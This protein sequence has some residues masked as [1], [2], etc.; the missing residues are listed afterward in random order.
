LGTMKSLLLAFYWAYRSTIEH[1]RTM[2]QG[3]GTLQ[4]QLFTRRCFTDQ[5]S[6]SETLKDGD[7]GHSHPLENYSYILPSSS[8][9]R[10]LAGST[11]TVQGRKLHYRNKQALSHEREAEMKTCE[12]LM[13]PCR[14]TGGAD[15]HV[16]LSHVRRSSPCHDMVC[17][18][19][20]HRVQARFM[21]SVNLACDARS[22]RSVKSSVKL[23]LTWY[24]DIAV[25]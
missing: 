19:S 7:P 1:F 21:V 10:A 23:A 25:S 9:Q 8:M 17:P 24:S 3:I 11:A 6:I 20:K 13:N 5:F 2:A 14:Q 15:L 18:L 12:N 16:H 22:T 4:H